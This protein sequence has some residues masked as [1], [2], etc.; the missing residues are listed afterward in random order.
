MM[1][2]FVNLKTTKKL[3]LGFGI[4]A[5]L[6]AVVGYQGLNGMNTIRGLMSDLYEKHAL[7]AANLLEAQNQLTAFSRSLSNSVIADDPADIEQRIK[8]N[9]QFATGFREDFKQ[10]QS[11]IVLDETRVKAAELAG[12]FDKLVDAS[13]HL[14]QLA[15]DNDDDAGQVELQRLR[16]M[17]NTVEANMEKLVENKLALMADLFQSANAT[18]SKSWTFIAGMIAIAVVVALS[19]GF[20]IAQMISRPLGK[21]VEVLAAVAKKDLTQGLAIDA[22]DEVGQ[23][24]SSLD[25]ALSS[26]RGAL[27]SFGQSSETLASS[28]EELT[29]VS[30]QLAASAEET[31]AQ[32]SAV[33]AAAEEVSRNVQ[34]V[35]AA[36]VEMGASIKEISQNASEAARVAA[37]AVAV[38]ESTN[39]TITKLGD[40]SVEIGNVIKVITTIAK[41]TNLLA[42]NAT[43]EAARAGEAGKGFAVVANEVKELAKQ[44]ADATE[45]IAQRIGAIQHDA[46]AAVSAIG[47]VSTIIDQIN[48]ISSTIA[49]AVEEQSATTSEISRNVEEA[50]RGSAEIAQNVTGVTQAAQTTASGATQT[51]AAAEELSRMAADLQGLVAQFRFTSPEQPGH[52]REDGP[53]RL[54]A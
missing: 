28:S 48:E 21:T 50:N 46:Q 3:M 27:S 34:T 31:S 37:Q 26:L 38:A 5:V 36:A 4:M 16:D 15:R 23:M 39:S 12:S 1:R 25:D 8:R 10:Y 33:A 7:G 49:S 35:A 30:H 22:K 20:M 45:D 54:A 14:E 32:S 13:R 19:I 44:T 17:S 41:Q 11:R 52:E 2:W 18:Y 42:L 47:E 9:A 24:A 29:S 53:Q 6:I 40:S 43:I 51:Q